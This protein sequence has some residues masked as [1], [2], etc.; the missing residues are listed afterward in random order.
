M[1]SVIGLT[2]MIENGA[3]QVSGGEFNDSERW[4]TVM[5]GYYYKR[6]GS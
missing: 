5:D 3:K 4:W 1:G 6:Y 2:I